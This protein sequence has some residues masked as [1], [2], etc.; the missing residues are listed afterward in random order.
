MK[1][2]T[3]FNYASRSLFRD[4]Q[5]TLLAIFCVAVGV[6]AIVTLQLVG[7]M[8][9]NAFNGNVRD[10][11]G[12]DIAIRSQQPFTVADLK[13]FA[14]WKQDGLITDYT[15]MVTS[16]ASTGAKAST[17]QT[18]SVRVIDAQHYPEATITSPTFVNPSHGSVSDLVKNDAVVVTQAFADQYK[19]HL[20]DSFDIIISSTRQNGRIVHAHIAGIV[21][22]TGVLAQSGSVVLL[23][24]QDYQASAPKVALSYDTVD[25]SAPSTKIDSAVKK[26][27]QQ[28]PIATTQTAAD[29]LKQQQSIIDNIRKF[30]EIAG[31]LALLIGGVGIVNTMQVL[32]SRRKA[33][34]AMLKTTGYRRFDL[35]LLFGLEAGLLGLIGGALGAG[36]ATLISY[37][38]RNLVVASFGLNVPFVLD[39]FTIL[40]GVVIGIATSL[41]F[42][43]LPIVQAA[44]IRPLNVIRELPE[45]RGKGSLVLMGFL[46]ILLSLLFCI[47]SIVILNG[48][49]RL[50]TI[51][52]YGIFLFLALLSLVLG[53]LIVLVSKLPVPE[54]VSIWHLLLVV[55]MLAISYGLY[56]VVP[57]YG[58]LFFLFSLAGLVVVFLP[59]TLKVTAKMALRNLSRQRARTTT[60]ML[61]L[62]VGIFTIGLILALGQNLRDQV[63]NVIAT[64]LNYNVYS[65]TSNDDTTKLR[66]KLASVPG[67]SSYQEHTLAT[68]TPLSINGEPF[69]SYLT[70]SQQ[71]SASSIRG[72]QLRYF[73]SGV[74]GYDVGN[75][76]LPRTNTLQIVSGRNLRPD[77]EGTNNVL[78][79]DALLKMSSLHLQIG[80]KIILLGA[81]GTSSKSVTAVGFYKSTTLGATFEPILGTTDTTRALSPAGFAQSVFYMKIDAA[82]LNSA[83]DIIGAT[84]PKAFLLNLASLT[85]FVNQLLNDI[86]LTL[87]TIASLTLLAGLIIIANAVALAMLER[88]R[89]LG[90]LKSVGYTSGTILSEVMLENGAVGGLGALVAMALASL[91]TWLLGTY[92]FNAHFTVNTPMVL[93][94]VLGSAALAMLIALIVAW[95]AVRVRPLEVLRY[96]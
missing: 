76:Q 9:N 77:D 6:M 60:T 73:L 89:E 49:V 45:G 4:G 95:G 15:P 13:H 36:A 85:D 90:I 80:S 33:E 70:G 68:T 84:V 42:G 32:L 66:A 16:Q 2:S 48:D 18:F 8:I 40:G 17:R 7:L 54:R 88:R 93:A 19:K 57:A 38:V 61:A 55:V 46:L 24:T 27:Q 28:F 71:R 67:L 5:R 41:I 51:T 72:S 23:A 83:V 63:N 62:F 12:G 58:M 35:Y 92:A 37:L 39:W 11:N 22:E 91:V 78:L 74:E 10:A 3:Y 94:I 59:R 30:L 81:D 87:T 31:L 53:L 56:R 47:L 20:G 14:T 86:L 82:K 29:V 52:V 69:Q 75:N 21:S 96:E 34:I 44:N 25:V 43:L 1:A 50:G 79:S 65:I 64:T 26:I